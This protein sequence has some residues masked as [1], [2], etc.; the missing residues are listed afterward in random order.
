MDL[1]KLELYGYMDGFI[2]FKNYYI[3]LRIQPLYKL[4]SFKELVCKEF[5]ELV[6]FIGV[7]L[8]FYHTSIAGYSLM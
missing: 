4:N 3:V 1:R 7:L 8:Y 6:Y 5:K 2:V